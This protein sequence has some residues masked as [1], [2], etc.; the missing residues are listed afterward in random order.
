LAI[1]LWFLTGALTVRAADWQKFPDCRL[2]E[3]VSNDGD[4]FHV[5]TAGRELLV[6]LYFVDCPETS[7]AS[8][9]DAK[10]VREQSRYFG[11]VEMARVV[12]YG[13][14]AQRFTAEVLKE[15]FTVHS[16]L[17]TAP[18]R[19][20]MPRMY[21]MV[22]TAAGKDLGTLLVERGLARVYGVK[23]S[24]PDGRTGDEMARQLQNRET[25]TM[26][27]RVG[28]WSETDATLIVQM[29]A[30]Q[31]RDQAE[32]QQLRRQIQEGDASPN[33]VDINT[34]S[35]RDL[36]SVSGIGPTLAARIIAGRP[37]KSVDDLLRISG[38]STKL[39]SRVREHLVV[40]KPP[41]P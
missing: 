6:R 21:C 38:I 32:L 35:S 20:A 12:H 28:I 18:G 30:E 23:R 40:G 26:L 27:Q 9:V 37:Y 10:R 17:A 4:S 36:Q 13:K 8:D 29:R 7:A 39:L 16:T 34:G 31:E 41:Q 14:E 5:R 22:T 19:S 11:L 24:T 33:P 3:N 2:I 15:P 25:G 1:L